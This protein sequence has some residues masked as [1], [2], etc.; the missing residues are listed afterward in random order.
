MF[1]K[2]TRG[3]AKDVTFSQAVKKGLSNDGGLFVPDT[4]CV[5]TDEEF[6]DMV[7]LSYRD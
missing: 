3:G 7:S 2:S 1:Y 4:R 6:K 5:L